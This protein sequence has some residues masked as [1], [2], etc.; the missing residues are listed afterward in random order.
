MDPTT[1]ITGFSRIDEKRGLKKAPESYRSGQSPVE[2][3]QKTSSALN[4]STGL[5]RKKKALTFLVSSKSENGVDPYSYYDLIIGAYKELSVLDKIV[6]LQIKEHIFI[7]ISYRYYPII[8][9]TI[10]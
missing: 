4:E 2:K 5:S 1:L 3:L 10:Y 7:K 6:Y 9:L 8:L